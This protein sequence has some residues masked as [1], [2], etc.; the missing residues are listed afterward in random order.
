M[1][2]LASLGTLAA[3]NVAGKGVAVAASPVLELAKNRARAYLG[4]KVVAETEQVDEFAGPIYTGVAASAAS[5]S[6]VAAA[7]AGADSAMANPAADIS[8]SSRAISRAIRE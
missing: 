2:L 4:G 3:V 5:A 6:S 7:P 1:S 8:A